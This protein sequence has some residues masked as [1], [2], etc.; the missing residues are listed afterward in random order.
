MANNKTQSQK[1]TGFQ[2]NRTKLKTA[3]AAQQDLHN[4]ST[5]ARP[6]VDPADVVVPDG[7]KIE[8][9][10]VG[11][12]FPTDVSFSDDGTIFVSE[13]GSSWP[14]RPYMP[15]RVIVRHPSGDTEAIS[16]NVHAGPRSVTWRDGE[17]Y[18]A[19]KGGYH[20]QIAKYNLSTRELKILIDQI[21][22]GGWHEPGG[23]VFGPDGMMYFGHGSVSQQGVALPAGFTV[24][25]AKHPNAHDVPG[26]DVTLTGNNVRSR[27]PRMPYPFMVDTGA[28]KPFGTS[29]KKGEVIKGELFCNSAVWRSRPDGS[30]VELLAWGIR[31]PFG[32]AISDGGEL[33]VTDNDFEEKGERAIAND[34]D[35]IWHI[36]NARKPF[37]SITTPDW[38]G[39]PDICGDGLPVNHEKHLPSRGTAAELLLENPPEWAGPAVFLEQPHSCMCKMDFSRSDAF[40]YKGELFVAEWGA[41]APLNSPRPEDLDHGFRVIRVDVQKGTAEPFMHNKKMG[42][43]STYGGG[44]IERPVSCKF[45]PDGKSLY[46]LDFG[47][48]KVTPGNMLAFAHTGVLWKISRKEDN[49]E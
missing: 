30:D 35:R 3:T 43:A 1:N 6:V 49:N 15:A 33:Y 21:P 29:A 26:Q 8:P 17:L 23:P 10:M 46:V 31:N 37:G 5:P 45:S 14:T 39:F 16:M 34:P 27:D 48:A 7:Y 28:F 22:S 20:M 18:M 24:D 40:G 38:Y 25:L 44:G 11:L 36:K 19:F 12:S 13:G 32:M 9:I 42:P 41:L 2:I 47:V 4:L